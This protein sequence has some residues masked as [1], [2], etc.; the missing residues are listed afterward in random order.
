MNASIIL[1]RIKQIDQKFSQQISQLFQF[2][3]AVGATTFIAT[4]GAGLSY[5]S[6]YKNKK[7]II[8]TNTTNDNNNYTDNPYNFVIYQE[9]NWTPKHTLFEIY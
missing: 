5:R 7:N 2:F 8:S 6:N 9:R 3:P 1:V 4:A